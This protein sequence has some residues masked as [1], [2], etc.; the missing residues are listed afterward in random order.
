MSDTVILNVFS[1]YV[2]P[3]CY[4]VTGRIERLKKEFNIELTNIPVKNRIRIQ[5]EYAGKEIAM[6]PSEKKIVNFKA[7][8][9]LKIQNRYIFHIKI[10]SEK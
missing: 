5:I 4:F 3:W 2:W 9:T 1:D 7:I 6:A 10:K 8:S